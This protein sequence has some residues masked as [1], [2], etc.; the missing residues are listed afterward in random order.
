MRL[1]EVKVQ[2]VI[3][4]TLNL[5]IAA[6]SATAAIQDAMKMLDS[7]QSWYGSVHSERPYDKADITAEPI[8]VIS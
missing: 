8:E 5:L 4:F 2:T 6:P 1:Y 7:L 3:G